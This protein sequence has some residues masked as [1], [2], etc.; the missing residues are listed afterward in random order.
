MYFL[1]YQPFQFKR[2]VT[3]LI[4]K[5]IPKLYFIT[6]EISPLLEKV[7]EEINA[8][9]KEKRSRELKGEKVK[10][11]HL[12]C[13]SVQNPWGKIKFDL[14]NPLSRR[15]N[16]LLYKQVKDNQGHIRTVDRRSNA[17]LI[18][19]TTTLLGMLDYLINKKSSYFYQSPQTCLFRSLRDDGKTPQYSVPLLDT[20]KYM[21]SAPGTNEGNK[22]TV[23]H[24]AQFHTQNA[25]DE[26]LN[27]E[28]QNAGLTNSVFSV[29]FFHL[30]SLTGTGQVEIP[31]LSAL[32]DVIKNIIRHLLDT[33]FRFDDD[34]FLI[35]L[36]NM[37]LHDA[38][39]AAMRVAQQLKNKKEFV[40][41]SYRLSAGAVQ[42]KQNWK[43]DKLRKLIN[44]VRLVLHKQ[45][46]SRIIFVDSDT[47]GLKALKLK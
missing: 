23:D 30:F 10:L 8:K 26:E 4:K 47:E 13:E 2:K 29:I 34:D 39:G 35:I 41:S 6:A 19:Y 32:A 43:A 38:L 37:S 46:L 9:F 33:P 1:P 45:K 15:L 7:M 21:K 12:T 40:D 17:N 28:I 36:K 16:E 27:R 44:K 11:S 14:E 42:F 20:E 5:N 3:L 25:L 18:I 22:A 24:G 31:V